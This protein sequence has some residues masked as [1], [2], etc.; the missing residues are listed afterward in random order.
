[1]RRKRSTSNIPFEHRLTLSFKDAHDWTGWSL[2]TLYTMAKRGEIQVTKAGAYSSIITKSLV[3]VVNAN[4][5]VA[6]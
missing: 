5:K 1:M 3:D 4:R 6:A 2:S